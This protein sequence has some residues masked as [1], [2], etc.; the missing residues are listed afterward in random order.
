M[1]IK[2]TTVYEGGAKAVFAITV[3]EEQ[4]KLLKESKDE[5][6]AIL[7]VSKKLVE[8][9]PF[10][11]AS[12]LKK[13]QTAQ[14]NVNKSIKE[15]EANEKAQF[16]A[17]SNLIKLQKQDEQ[18]AR[19]RLKTKNQLAKESER[20]AKAAKKQATEQQKLN[21]VFLQQKNE[22]KDLTLRYQNLAARGKG[23]GKVARGL[24]NE[25]IALNAEQKRINK[26]IGHNTKTHS[27]PIVKTL[28]QSIFY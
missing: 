28:F 10:K 14:D 3:I 23:A 25:I 27:C 8:E 13:F 6:N 1:G 7:Q 16:I 15:A 4:I 22:L 2:Q 12:D 26:T 17:K 24:K 18:L 19:E 9:N 5:L 11:N 20:Q 21:N